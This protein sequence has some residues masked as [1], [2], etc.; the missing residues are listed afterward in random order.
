MGV[1]VLERPAHAAPRIWWERAGYPPVLCR[2]LVMFQRRWGDVFGWGG[3]HNASLLASATLA[4]YAGYCGRAADFLAPY[5]ARTMMADRHKPVE[6]IAEV[7]LLFLLAELANKH[8]GDLLQHLSKRGE[9]R[10]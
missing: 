3:F 2:P 8:K 9:R 7:S 10:E 4:N 5:I 6:R 1:F